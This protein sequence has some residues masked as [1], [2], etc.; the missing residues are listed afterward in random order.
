MSVKSF[1]FG[2]R[3]LLLIASFFLLAPYRALSRYLVRMPLVYLTWRQDP[4]STIVVNWMDNDSNS[5]D[6]VMYRQSAL[7]LSSTWKLAKGYKHN[8]ADDK[9][10]I[11]HHV[12]LQGLNPDT[13]Y[14]FTIGSK[15]PARAENYLKFRTLPKLMPSNFRFVTGGDMMHDRKK[16]DAMNQRAAELNPWFALLG[17][18]LAYANADKKNVSNWEDWLES[19]MLNCVRKSD[20]GLIPM[21]VAIGN[22]E[23]AGGTGKKPKDA[24]YFYSLFPMPAKRS[25]YALD[26]GNYLSL[27]LLDSDLTERIDGEQAIWLEKSLSQRF[28]KVPFVFAC[29]H[30]PA[31]GT[32]KPPSGTKDSSK[33]PLAQKIIKYWCPLFDKYNVTA[34]FE[35]DHHTYK[36]TH[37]LRGNRIDRDRGVVYLGDGC[38]GV[39][40]RDVPKPGEVWYLAKA[41]SKRHLICVTIRNG[42]SDYVAYEANGKVIDRHS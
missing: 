37:P 24:K 33:D 14:I 35:N 19:W 4:T 32:A 28:G 30:K 42:K 34:V 15:G 38:W 7:P 36:R 21:V 20:G 12:E 17:G 6:Y 29:Y 2:R 1:K 40:T 5:P 27:I 31:Y 39:D 10:R 8:F 9:K 13:E 11:I 26:I 3:L 41:E 25:F 16:V 23:V 22:H 18:D